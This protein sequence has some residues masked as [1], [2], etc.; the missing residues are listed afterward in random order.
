M[1]DGRSQ[2]PVGPSLLHSSLPLYEPPRP[3]DQPVPEVILILK[4]KGSIDLI[5][6]GP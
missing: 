5:S 4:A 1:E 3:A 6:W 2:D